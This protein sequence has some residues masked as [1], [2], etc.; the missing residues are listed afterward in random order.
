MYILIYPRGSNEAIRGTAPPQQAGEDQRAHTYDAFLLA[1]RD[2]GGS[3]LCRR[4]GLGHEP[5]EIATVDALDGEH[6]DRGRGVG[7]HL[8]IRASKIN[9]LGLY[10]R[11]CLQAQPR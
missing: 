11:S 4:C 6:Q 7:M 3:P 9:D 1:R 2:E 8:L 5:V 10:W